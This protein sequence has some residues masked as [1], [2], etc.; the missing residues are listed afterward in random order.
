[1]GKFDYWVILGFLGQLTFSMRFIVQWI[2]SERRKESYIPLGFWYLSLVG[3]VILL[4]YSISR[5]DPVFIVGQASGLIVYI[6]N[7]ML[8]RKQKL[9]GED[10]VTVKGHAQQQA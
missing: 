5:R 10:L 6:R 1:M 7:I 3:G 4:I 8:I 2:C 9:G